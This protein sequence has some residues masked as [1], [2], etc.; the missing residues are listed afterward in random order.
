MR[1]NMKIRGRAK[2]GYEILEPSPNEMFLDI[3]CSEG[4]LER[5]L[6][7]T[8]M[9]NVYAIDINEDSIRLVAKLSF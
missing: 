3:G 9:K 6:F 5:K 2:V 7:D 4:Y 8:G 1:K